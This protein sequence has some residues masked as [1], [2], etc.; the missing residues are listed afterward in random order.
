M[1]HDVCVC[2]GGKPEG[3]NHVRSNGLLSLCM[4]ILPCMFIMEMTV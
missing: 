1:C 3:Y 2:G 4:L